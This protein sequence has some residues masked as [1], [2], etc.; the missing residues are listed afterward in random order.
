MYGSGART[1]GVS[2]GR[3]LLVG[4]SPRKGFWANVFVD[5][6]ASAGMESCGFGSGRLATKDLGSGV[7]RGHCLVRKRSG[8]GPQER[9]GVSVS[10]LWG[11]Q[12]GRM[13]LEA[14][15]EALDKTGHGGR[16]TG[17]KREEACFP[18]FQ[19]PRQLA[20]A[21]SRVDVQPWGKARPATHQGHGAAKPDGG[22]QQRGGASHRL[23][24]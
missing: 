10:E 17:A 18:S 4:G 6:R 24:C 1:Q 20:A 23:G 14:A 2:R 12:D 22:R 15:S 5:G 19:L 3:A 21:L 7:P 9:V 16:T 8:C 13:T 11:W